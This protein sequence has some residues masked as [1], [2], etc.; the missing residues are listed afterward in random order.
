MVFNIEK[1]NILTCLSDGLS[2]F[3]GVRTRISIGSEVDDRDARANHLKIM[4]T[5]GDNVKFNLKSNE[6]LYCRKIIFNVILIMDQN[7]ITCTNHTH[8]AY[9]SQR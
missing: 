7:N 4:C 3:V 1:T 8:N 5:K 2:R 6:S 9:L